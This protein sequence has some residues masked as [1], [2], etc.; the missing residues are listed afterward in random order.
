[1]KERLSIYDA[2]SVLESNSL[3][4]IT[5]SEWAE[6]MG[7]S[8]SHFC[9]KFTFEF[10]INPKCYL[11]DFRLKL[12]KQ[13]IRKDPEAIGYCIAVNCGFIDE[14][15]LHKYLDFNFDLCLSK[16]KAQVK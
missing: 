6:I 7:Y 10:G 15:A 3:T 8:R 11:K 2:L 14:K 4:I 1:M 12:I 5:V 13:E 9:R 16:V